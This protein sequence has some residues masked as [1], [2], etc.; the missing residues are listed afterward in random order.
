MIYATN[1]FQCTGDKMF[2]LTEEMRER[3][4]AANRERIMAL[5]EQLP[6]R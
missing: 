2:V 6:R 5:P 4:M 1:I 3:L